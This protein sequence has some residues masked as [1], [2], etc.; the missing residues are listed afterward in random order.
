[1]KRKQTLKDV[2]W[3]GLECG[4]EEMEPREVPMKEVSW[5]NV[6]PLSSS[7]QLSFCSV[8]CSFKKKLRAFES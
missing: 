7:L 6:S 2:L 8:L 3:A 4:H 1:M 5:M